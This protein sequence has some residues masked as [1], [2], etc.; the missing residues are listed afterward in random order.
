MVQLIQINY[1]NVHEIASIDISPVV[2]RFLELG[3]EWTIV[4]STVDTKLLRIDIYI[5]HSGKNLVCPETGVA[6]MLYDHREER[7]WRHRNI[8]SYSRTVLPDLRYFSAHLSINHTRTVLCKTTS[9]R[10]I[11]HL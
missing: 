11:Q 8:R 5:V 1:H 6:G 9:K 3:P 4:R 10:S 7:T 2:C